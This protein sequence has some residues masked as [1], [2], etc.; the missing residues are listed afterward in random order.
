MYANQF[1]PWALE[2]LK[3]FD[4]VCKYIFFS[5]SFYNV[6]NLA[7]NMSCRTRTGWSHQL[8]TDKYRRPVNYTLK[9]RRLPVLKSQNFGASYIQ[10]AGWLCLNIISVENR[11]SESAQ[12]CCL[13]KVKDNLQFSVVFC[14][15]FDTIKME[16]FPVIVVPSS[17]LI[18]A[19]LHFIDS[20]PLLLISVVQKYTFINGEGSMGKV[21]DIYTT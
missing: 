1:S 19:V 6:L 15:I 5:L 21:E 10:Y 8:N 12:T 2:V 18:E 16:S 9:H 20:F 14:Y 4:Y 11:V 17:S 13:G 7:V 3:R